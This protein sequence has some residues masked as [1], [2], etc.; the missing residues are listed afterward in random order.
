MKLTSALESQMN[1]EDSSMTSHN[2]RALI[3]DVTELRWTKCFQRGSQAHSATSQHET[4]SSLRFWTPNMLL[5]PTSEEGQ[6]FTC[7][8]FPVVQAGRYCLAVAAES[9][10]TNKNLSQT[11]N[12]YSDMLLVCFRFWF[13]FVLSLSLFETFPQEKHF[14][15]PTHKNKSDW[16]KHNR[17]LAS[18][19]QQW[20]STVEEMR[21]LSLAKWSLIRSPSQPTRDLNDF[22]IGISSTSSLLC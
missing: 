9:Q 18:Q 22:P 20:V 17:Q 8:Y 5:P 10:I 6:H 15:L 12:D 7:S 13:I 3:P 11:A 16:S 1:H 4:L 21:V 19:Q 14:N 2:A